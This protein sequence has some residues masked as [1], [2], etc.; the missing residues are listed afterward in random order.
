MYVLAIAQYRTGT[1][2]HRPNIG[3]GRGAVTTVIRES[4]RRTDDPLHPLPPP[5]LGGNRGALS[6]GKGPPPTDRRDCRVRGTLCISRFGRPG[7]RFRPRSQ[8][9]GNEG[10]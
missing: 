9:V 1:D 7:L 10:G 8:T 3:Q 4:C 2:R 5:P 6:R